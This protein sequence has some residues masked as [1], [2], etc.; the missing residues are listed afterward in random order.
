MADDKHRRWSLGAAAALLLVLGTGPAGSARASATELP[1]PTLSSEEVELGDTITISG[2]GCT[3]PDTSTAEGVEMWVVQFN[4]DGR[5]SATNPQAIPVAA[6]GSYTGPFTIGQPIPSGTLRLLLRCVSASG[7]DIAST[8][9]AIRST[10]PSLPDLVVVPGTTATMLAPCSTGA[11]YGIS[12][13]GA[14]PAVEWLEATDGPTVAGQPTKVDVPAA[15]PTGTYDGRIACRSDVV[16]AYFTLR[17]I[18][19]DPAPAPTP[20][21]APAPA[22]PAVPQAGSS[23]YTG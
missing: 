18:V 11:G 19:T 3:D 10:A 22:P 12:L 1:A 21:P 6:D 15:L 7:A 9:V 5:P 16:G 13:R 20:A 23:D 4:E 2:T 17:V 14:P 8:A